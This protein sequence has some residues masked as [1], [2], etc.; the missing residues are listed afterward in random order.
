MSAE[1]DL[2]GFEMPALLEGCVQNLVD[3]YDSRTALF[4][5]STSLQGGEYVNVYDHPQAVRYTINSLLGLSEAARERVPGI[6]ADD[7]QTMIDSFVS[8]QLDA[9]VTCADAG[10]LT[11]LLAEHRPE[12]TETVAVSLR[13]V[14]D[15]VAGRGRREL[16]MQDLAW[17][18]WGASAAVRRGLPGGE[19]SA[20]TLFRLVTS[21]YVDARTW[22]PRHSV[23]RYRRN[24]V[25]FGSLVYFLRAT[26]E[27]AGTF[28]DDTARELF[29]RGV[30]RTLGLQGPRGEWPWMIDIRSGDAF[31]VYPVF[32]VHQDSMAM[33]FLLPAHDLRLDG[34]AESIIRSLAWGFGANELAIDFYPRNP[35]FAY[36]SIERKE[37]SPRLRRY[38]RS[39]VH[40]A[41]G[42]PGAFGDADVRLNPECRSYHLGW[43][44]YA[45]ARRPEV[46]L[47][48][49]P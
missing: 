11:L 9:V 29:A 8:Q 31:D 28:D 38:V 39:L 35:F 5:Y 32:S 12:Q 21:E 43:I 26:H 15:H 46:E 23:R 45:W 41:T 37:E 17:A 33:L 3:T 22:L 6:S 7:V 24:V 34:T 19:A 48:S 14:E 49:D 2:T 42:K 10:L 36:R 1:L 44:L 30:T 4:P 47:R 16:N 25:S 20:R 40:A 18:I 13:R 27:F